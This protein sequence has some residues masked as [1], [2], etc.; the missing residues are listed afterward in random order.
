MIAFEKLL[1]KTMKTIKR[2]NYKDVKMFGDSWL[3]FKDVL[4]N[5]VDCSNQN[6]Y[7]LELFSNIF[8][9]YNHNYIFVEQ[10]PELDFEIPAEAQRGTLSTVTSQSP[11]SYCLFVLIFALFSGLLCL[12]YLCLWNASCFVALRYFFFVC[13]NYKCVVAFMMYLYKAM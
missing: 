11:T 4:D 13:F 3:G 1:Q 2:Y 5:I 9:L 8:Q 10:I 7:T 12:M 6:R